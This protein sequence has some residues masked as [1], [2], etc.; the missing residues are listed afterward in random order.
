MAFS[1]A[2]VTALERAIAAGTLSVQLGDRRI[3]YQSMA[4]LIRARD[5]AKSEVASETAGDTK[6]QRLRRYGVFS[7]G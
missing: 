7:R 6:A 4:D 3:T 2:D 5:L 1:A